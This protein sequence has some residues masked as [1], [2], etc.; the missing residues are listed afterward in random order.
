M[1]WTYRE[2]LFCNKH[3]S[4]FTPIVAGSSHST[5]GAGR[6]RRPL[7]PH[8]LPE[9]QDLLRHDLSTGANVIKLF[10]DVIYKWA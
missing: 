6:V 2:W 3:S 10:T 5:H 4:L 7:P 9:V 8:R 1:L